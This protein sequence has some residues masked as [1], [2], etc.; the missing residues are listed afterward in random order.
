MP[1]PLE[2]EYGGI[3]ADQ[4][5]P[6]VRA[7][8]YSIDA[9]KK[10]GTQV[11][12]SAPKDG[13][14]LA[15]EHGPQQDR[16]QVK[17]QEERLTEE[18]QEDR[19]YEPEAQEAG[20][21]YGVQEGGN[22]YQTQEDGQEG[23]A[24]GNGAHEDRA[25]EDG[26]YKDGAY[27]DGVHE[28]GA[29]EDAAHNDK[30]QGGRQADEVQEI[31][32]EDKAHKEGQDGGTYEDDVREY[33]TRKRRVMTEESDDGAALRAQQLRVGRKPVEK[34]K[35][36]RLNRF[37]SSNHDMNPEGDTSIDDTEEG[38]NTPMQRKKPQ[39]P[40]RQQRQELQAQE[41]TKNATAATV[42][43]NTNSSTGFASDFTYEAPQ[44]PSRAT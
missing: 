12:I 23:R 17:G 21:E 38:E 24:H 9:V 44:A 13:N 39:T 26:A 3:Y 16:A 2:F 28:D 31:L 37:G 29:Y 1:S 25:Y 6:E 8:N 33:R 5:A 27:E 18:A 41:R 30:A 19:S 42:V 40:R 10:G 36:Q 20:Q 14:S 11:N 43:E 32:Q 34:G 22:E 4:S 15:Q 35:Y 7:K